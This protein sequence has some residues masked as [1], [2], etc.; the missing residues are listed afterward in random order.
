MLRLPVYTLLQV[1]LLVREKQVRR[2]A[3]SSVSNTVQCATYAML[4][5]AEGQATEAPRCA[6]CCGKLV[7]YNTL[8]NVLMS[9]DAATVHL[10]AAM[11]AAG[12][13][14]GRHA[15]RRRVH[16]FVNSVYS[17]AAC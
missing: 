5:V 12:M 7:C 3:A 8:I 10:L 4:V 6:L 1:G 14:V 16:L 11:L 9:T 13:C 2:L 17:S 15:C